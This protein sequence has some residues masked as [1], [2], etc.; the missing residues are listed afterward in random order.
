MKGKEGDRATR[1]AAAR[2]RG[3]R[4]GDGSDGSDAPG[5]GAGQVSGHAAAIRKASRIDAMGIDTE[6]A[7]QIVQHVTDEEEIVDPVGKRIIWSSN[8]PERVSGDRVRQA[9]RVDGDEVIGFCQVR[10]ACVELDIGSKAFSA[11]EDQKNRKRLSRI[12]GGGEVE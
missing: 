6:C 12:I 3:E 4:C 5:Q 9:L 10:E 8:G 2:V 7:L 11:M 1:M